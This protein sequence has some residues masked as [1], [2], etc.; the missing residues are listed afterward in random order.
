MA[1]GGNAKWV[2]AGCM[3]GAMI[4]EA[5]DAANHAGG[6]SG[7]LRTRRHTVATGPDIA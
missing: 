2:R 4:V 1:V 7:L 3:M 5:G 6:G